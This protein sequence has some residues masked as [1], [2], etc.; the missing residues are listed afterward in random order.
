MILGVCIVLENTQSQLASCDLAHVFA[1][2]CQS[3]CSRHLS[4]PKCV[5]DASEMYGVM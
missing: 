1:S 4:A 2:G 5:L 3:L